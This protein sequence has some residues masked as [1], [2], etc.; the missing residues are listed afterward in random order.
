MMEV[1]F[2]TLALLAQGDP[3]QDQARRRA[4][5]LRQECAEALKEADGVGSVG[6]GGSGD[7]WRLLIAVRDR[8]ALRAVKELVGGDSYGG[9]RIVW[10]VAEP[11]RPGPPPSA[12]PPAPEPLREKPIPLEPF[13][14]RNNIWQA[15]I[16]DCDII[17]DYLKLK[18]VQHPSGN[19]MSWVPCQVVQRTSIGPDGGHSFTYTRHRPDCP[20][21][22]GRVG[23][24]GWSD[25]Y[26]AWVFRSGMTSPSPTNF[27]IPGNHWDFEH[28]SSNDMASRLPQVREG[29][30]N[31]PVWPYGPYAYGPYTRPYPS[32]YYSY[33][34]YPRYTW[35]WW[36]CRPYYRWWGWRCR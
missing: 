30:T 18:K 28:Q 11:V 34:W 35:R 17:R 31:V 16:T 29:M 22:M 19:G 12:A 25:N 36:P 15:S 6:L 8:E 4:A 24:P 13:E 33:Y 3:A 23:E 7:D 32:S 21:R 2:C 20:V 27:T 26:M 5:E 10:S 14:N 9:L 1:L